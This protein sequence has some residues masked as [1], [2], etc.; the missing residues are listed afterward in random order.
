MG[1]FS[2]WRKEGPLI[3]THVSLCPHNVFVYPNYLRLGSTVLL[4]KKTEA[5]VS[6][7]RRVTYGS[8]GDLALPL[9]SGRE[10]LPVT[11][12]CRRADYHH[13][14]CRSFVGVHSHFLYGGLPVQPTKPPHTINNR[15]IIAFFLCLCYFYLNYN[16]L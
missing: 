15:F 9:G 12:V 8:R 11:P 2:Y 1:R 14:D 6:A 10:H 5:V 3:N 7:R 16:I 4:W 13:D